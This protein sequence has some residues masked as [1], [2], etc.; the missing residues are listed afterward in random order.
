MCESP[1]SDA[2]G[3]AERI[4]VRSGGVLAVVDY[5]E[6]SESHRVRIPA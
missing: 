3:S 1:L 6:G 4:A 5:F 2:R